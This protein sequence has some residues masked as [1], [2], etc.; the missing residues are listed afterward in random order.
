VGCLDWLGMQVLRARVL[1]RLE[2]LWTGSPFR[3]I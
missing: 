2:K 3:S 1:R